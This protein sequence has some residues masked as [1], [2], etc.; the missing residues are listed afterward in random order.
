MKLN[1]GH[2]VHI[3]KETDKNDPFMFLGIRERDAA[4]IF[5][6]MDDGEIIGSRDTTILQSENNEQYIPFANGI[7]QVMNID[8]SFDEFFKIIRDHQDESSVGKW[9][10]F[11][12]LKDDGTISEVKLGNLEGQENEKDCINRIM[13][14][15][16]EDKLLYV[17]DD[18]DDNTKKW[19]N[20]IKKEL[21]LV[22]NA[23]EVMIQNEDT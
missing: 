4:M 22:N 17:V 18:C 12:K 16:S 3:Q 5:V 8:S 10:L 9:I 21:K 1:V 14:V 23:H 11:V 2:M 20:D 15:D 6:N 7:C 13:F 19:Y